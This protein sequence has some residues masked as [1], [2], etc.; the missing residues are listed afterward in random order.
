MI[1]GKCPTVP[2]KVHKRIEEAIIGKGTEDR[3]EYEYTDNERAYK[4]G[5]VQWQAVFETK[6]EHG[7]CGCYEEEIEID[8]E[9]WV[10]GFNYGH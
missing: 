7:C 2:E 9:K 10:I 5:E 1:I 3:P 6:K 4:V 8:G